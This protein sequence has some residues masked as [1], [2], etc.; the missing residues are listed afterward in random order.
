M[1]LLLPTTLVLVTPVPAQ[2]RANPARVRLPSLA[3]PPGRSSHMKAQGYD[4]AV[5]RT[6]DTHRL[7][8]APGSPQ[9]PAKLERGGGSAGRARKAAPG[10]DGGRPS[11]GPHGSSP[12]RKSTTA[13]GLRVSPFQTFL[14]LASWAREHL[15][16][17]LMLPLKHAPSGP[18]PR[19][20]A[21]LRAE[22]QPRQA[23]P[24]L[25]SGLCWK[26]LGLLSAP[27]AA[28]LSAS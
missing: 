20:R 16:D 19:E 10:P 4:D 6:A 7:P 2:H 14:L 11:P 17:E 27:K 25:P 24:Q 3:G 23:G 18:R 13:Q 8:M 12:G 26:S 1:D 15:P 21:G 22:Q 5:G 9:S 28:T